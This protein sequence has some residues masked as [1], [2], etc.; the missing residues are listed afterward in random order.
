MGLRDRG[1]YIDF[2]PKNCADF[3]QNDH[4]C[5]DQWNGEDFSIFSQDDLELPEK[6]TSSST[7]SCYLTHSE[8]RITEQSTKGNSYVEDIVPLGYT[9]SD[10]DQSEE[11]I[12]RRRGYRA[13]E[14]YLRPSP[15]RVKGQLDSYGFDL[16]KCTFTMAMTA[17]ATEP[18]S[19]SEIYLPY[20]HFAEG[21]IA[22]TVSDGKWYIVEQEVNGLRIQC[23]L[24][25]HDQGKV[26]IKV[27][28]K[29]LS[30]RK[31][32]IGC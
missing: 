1:M 25:W 20:F 28:G 10:C 7:S 27:K 16:K 4:A 23:L 8:S 18:H 22:V 13:A 30:P 6:I 3:A 14:A 2:H 24:W 15:I 9:S 12:T 11:V 19:P 17:Q 21:K 31:L 29:H 26:E 32:G 5:G